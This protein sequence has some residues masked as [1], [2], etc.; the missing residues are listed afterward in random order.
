MSNVKLNNLSLKYKITIKFLFLKEVRQ[1]E[2][3]PATLQHFGN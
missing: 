1:A 3:P 2:A